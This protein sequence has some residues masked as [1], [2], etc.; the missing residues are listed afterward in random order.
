[1]TAIWHRDDIQALEHRAFRAAWKLAEAVYKVYEPKFWEGKAG[2]Q[3]D[4]FLS[5]L[6]L[7]ACSGALCT[8]GAVALYTDSGVP[9]WIETPW[10]E[11]NC[12]YPITSR[13]KV[14][15]YEGGTKHSLEKVCEQFKI[16]KGSSTVDFEL[17]SKRKGR[18]GWMGHLELTVKQI[19]DIKLPPRKREQA[20]RVA[21]SHAEWIAMC[22]YY[23]PKTVMPTNREQIFQWLQRATES[24][25]NAFS[26]LS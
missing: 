20:T 2:W 13:G 23:Y 11:W 14:H 8:T 7:A 18:F 12:F 19:G 4:F 26:R 25:Q 16:D 1:M 21:R 22:M 9:L 3:K 15:G 24:Q 6:P 17:L 10:G 5:T